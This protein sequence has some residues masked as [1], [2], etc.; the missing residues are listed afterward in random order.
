M[1]IAIEEVIAL[2]KRLREIETPDLKDIEWTIGGHIIKPTNSQYKDFD[3]TGLAN[4]DFITD[5]LKN[6]FVT[7]EPFGERESHHAMTGE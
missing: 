6:P 5:D 4:R 1:R 2:K 7:I 3:Y